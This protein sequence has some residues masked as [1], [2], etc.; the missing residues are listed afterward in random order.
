MTAR[1]GLTGG[2]LFGLLGVAAGAFGA[3][4]LK[5]HLTE[6][7]TLAVW[8]T[9]SDY[10]LAHAVALVA[11]GLLAQRHRTRPTAV[12]AWAFLVGAV[13]FSGTLWLLAVSGIK[14]LGAITPIGGTSLLIGWG[15]LAL[16]G[17]R[18]TS[19]PSP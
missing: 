13:I 19:P 9:A 6:L 18:A 4:G 11:V 17:W 12:A 5:P 2:A 7:G 10:A 15:A 16:A 14:W 1:L 3:H 8:E